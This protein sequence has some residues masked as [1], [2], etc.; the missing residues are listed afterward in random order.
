MHGETLKFNIHYYHTWLYIQV[1]C[2]T[3]NFYRRRTRERLL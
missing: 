2:I 1:H 3:H